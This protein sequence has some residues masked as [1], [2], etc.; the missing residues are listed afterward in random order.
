APDRIPASCEQRCIPPRKQDLE[1]RREI[2]NVIH[3][4]EPAV[5]IGHPG[6]WRLTGYHPLQADGQ[7]M[8]VAPTR[9]AWRRDPATTTIFCHARAT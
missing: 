7:N 8:G 9:P 2:T 6:L 5:H 4:I 3:C 1:K